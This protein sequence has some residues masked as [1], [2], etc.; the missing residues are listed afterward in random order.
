M[1][2]TKEYICEGCGKVTT[3]EE[4]LLNY[5]QCDDCTVMNDLSPFDEDSMAHA[6]TFGQ[7]EWNDW[8]NNE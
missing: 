7:D 6:S 3:E 5:R 1:K 8:G 2:K 4:F